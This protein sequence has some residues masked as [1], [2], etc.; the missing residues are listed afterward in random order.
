MK[1]L[2]LILLFVTTL[3]LFPKYHL[4]KIKL[5][6]EVERQKLYSLNLDFE[7]AIDSKNE[8]LLVVNDFEKS[9]IEKNGFQTETIINDYEQYLAKE[10]EKQADKTQ[11]LTLDGFEFGSMG[12][13]YTLQEIYAQFNKLSTNNPFFIVSDTIGFSWE[14]NPIIAYCFGSKDQN[15]PEILLTALH[16]SR[17][18]ATVTTL[19][20]FLQTLFTKSNQ[21]DDEAN[22][23]L[24]NR[25]IWVIPVVNPDGYLYNQRNYPKGGGLWRK[26]RRPLSSSDTGV[27]LNR[28]YGPYEFWNAPNNGS[29]TNPKN[30]TYRGPSPFSEP[31]I[32]AIRNF[33]MNKSFVLALNFHTYGG[34]FIYP[35]SALPQETPD[36]NWYRSFGKYIQTLNSYYFGT[37]QQTVGYPTRGSSDD[38]F[39]TVDSSKGKI[40][41]ASPE[42]SYQFDGFYPPKERIL[43]IA[44]ENYPLLTNFLWSAEDNVKLIDYYYSFD[45]SRKAGFLNLEFQNIGVQATT[46][47]PFVRITSLSDK[48]YFDTSFYI[49]PLNSVEKY[50]KTIQLPV[51]NVDFVNGSEVNFSIIIDQNNIPRYDTFKIA[52]YE[53]QIINLMDSS[54]WNFSLGSWGYEYYPDSN[55]II[56]ADSPYSRYQDSVDNYLFSN[57]PIRL[58]GNNFEIEIF[59]RWSV[60]P[61]YDFAKFEISTNSGKDWIPLRFKRSTIASGNQYG[62]Q[63]LGEFGFSGYYPY[64]NKQIISLREYLW[65]D[66]LFKLSLL[67]D[68]GKNSLGWD[69]RELFLRSYPNIDF[70]NYVPVSDNT[71]AI[72]LS[73]K[74]NIIDRISLPND[75]QPTHISLYDI[76]GRKIY[77]KELT[78]SNQNINLELPALPLGVYLVQ[79]TGN[80]KLIIE[81]FIVE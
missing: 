38:W 56:L 18:P 64:W 1:K 30:E 26:N 49:K 36:S 74:S 61:F 62:K 75:F 2:I 13:F 65:K 48:Y 8:I 52:L 69:I 63:K 3:E 31:E 11:E 42:A 60:E 68:R 59:S 27:D 76:L 23:L 4:L 25:R 29:S 72:L 67:S 14:K 39:Y 19:V 77:T 55:F 15:K 66:V 80:G 81:K 17:E 6:N 24:Q 54:F 41:A 33:C 70:K 10:I 50:E 47:N 22:F 37:D 34:M 78:S 73:L 16:H 45:T 71:Q 58:G 5:S 44:K 40:L 28:N 32:V 51:P 57:K 43:E 9:E 35:Y 12:G 79:I 21:G 7:S 20:Y 46:R 53:Y